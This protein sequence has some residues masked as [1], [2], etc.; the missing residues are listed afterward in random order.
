MGHEFVHVLCGAMPGTREQKWFEESLCE[1]AALYALR[2]VAENY[3]EGGLKT[4]KEYAS[5]LLGSAKAT[6]DSTPN[7]ESLP[8]WY[9]QNQKHLEGNP[10]DYDFNLPATKTLLEYFERNP[11][12]WA[13]L[14]HVNAGGRK[15]KS[16]NSRLSSWRNRVKPKQKHHVNEIAE[17]FGIHLANPE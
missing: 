16:F 6:L 3:M 15:Q 8:K 4:E 9:R 1:C 11:D 10:T 14:I 2:R 12:A 5:L 17:L 7:I 13:T